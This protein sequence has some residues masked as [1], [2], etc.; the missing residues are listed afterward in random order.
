VTAYEAQYPASYLRAEGAITSEQL[1]RAALRPSDQISIEEID[2]A[3]LPAGL[4]TSAPNLYGLIL[5]FLNGKQLEPEEGSDEDQDE[6]A[7]ATGPSFAPTIGD[8]RDTI[9]R[10][11]KQR[12]GQR[13][14]RT[15][16]IK[17]YGSLCMISGCSVLDVLEAA[18]IAPYRGEADHHVDNGLLLRGDL[19]TLF[20]LD[21]LAIHPDKL[22]VQLSKKLSNS[23]YWEF[24]DVPLKLSGKSGPAAAPLAARWE[25]FRLAEK[26][27]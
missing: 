12:R 18:H 25:A 15:T 9:L 6:Q 16:L 8:M 20:D 7:E 1:K 10:A 5:G 27:T 21:L 14:F 19:H 24:H 11:I 3:T 23:T 22:T 26:G 4:R 2:P 13:K 17:R